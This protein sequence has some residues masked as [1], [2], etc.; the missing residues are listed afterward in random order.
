ME[1]SLKFNRFFLLLVFAFVSVLSFGQKYTGLTAT[2]S[3]GATPTGLFDGNYTGGWQDP[4][5]ADGTAV[6][7][8]LGSVKNVNSVK[9]YWEAA[10]AKAYNLLVSSDNTNWTTVATKTGMAAGSRA[11]YITDLNV[12]CQYIKMQG[13]T[14]Q[15]NYGYNIYEFEVYDD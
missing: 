12:S 5:N 6:T 14:R 8:N 10:N 7:V 2:A 9:I 11:D 4:T 1:K 15:L 13:V 3:T